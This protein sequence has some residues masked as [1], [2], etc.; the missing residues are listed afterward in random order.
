MVNKTYEASS[1]KERYTYPEPAATASLLLNTAAEVS[2]PQKINDRTKK[3]LKEVIM[4]IRTISSHEYLDAAI[5]HE[6]AGA[7]YI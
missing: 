5:L 4:I 7:T 1:F 2:T 6:Q 3:H